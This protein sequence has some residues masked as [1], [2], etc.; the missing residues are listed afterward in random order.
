M[1]KNDETAANGKTT[2]SLTPVGEFY[3]SYDGKNVLKKDLDSGEYTKLENRYQDYKAKGETV[4]ST[5]KA[6]Q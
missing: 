3:I 5:K 1:K 4:S 6:K 2:F